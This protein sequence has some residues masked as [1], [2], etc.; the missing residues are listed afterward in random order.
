MALSN[1]LR[2]R[3]KD[4]FVLDSNSD[5]AVRTNVSTS[6]LPSGASTDES[7]QLLNNILKELKI[8]NLYHAN[9]TNMVIT[10][11]EVE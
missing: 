5:T 9:M 8:L 11:E 7:V 1:A 2:D 4:K 3:E 6:A 10:L